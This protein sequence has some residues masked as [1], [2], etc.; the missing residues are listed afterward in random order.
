MVGDILR[1]LVARTTAQQVSTEAEA[2]TA[3]LQYAPST[4]AGCECVAHVMQA[5]TDLNPEA[6]VVSIDATGAYDMS[7]RNAMLEGLLQLENGDQVPSFARNFYGRRLTC[8]RREGGRDGHRN[9][10]F[11]EEGISDN[12]RHSWP[13]KPGCST[14]RTARVG[15]VHTILQEE[16][17][18]LA[19]I[20]V[21]Q[22]KTQVWNRGGSRPTSGH[23]DQGSPGSQS[24][25]PPS[26]KVISICRW[27]VRVCEYWAPQS[28]RRSTS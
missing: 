21:H 26:G 24:R 23:I 10:I 5:L 14:R 8:V 27:I 18:L 1:R 19:R 17:K 16:L 15:D 2:A 9:E 13:S 28:A 25:C 11:Q 4:R 20:R 22:G 7:S 12:A 6:T 3:L